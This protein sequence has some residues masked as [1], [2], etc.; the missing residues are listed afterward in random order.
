MAENNQDKNRTDSFVS[1]TKGVKVGHYTIIEK[2]GAG[3][4]GEVYLAEDTELKRQVALKFLPYHFVSDETAK[5]RFTRE[6]QAAAKLNHPN[7]VTIY[8]VSN[9][10]GRPFFAM[11]CCDGKPLRDIIKKIELS[12]DD[13]IKLTIQICEGLEKAHQAGIVHRDIKPSNIVIGSDERPKLLDFGLATVKGTEKLTQTGS[14]LG[15]IGYMSPEQI[16]VKEIDH[17]SDLFSL[18][19]VFYEMITG[20]LPFKGDTE[21]GTLNSILNDTPEPLSRYK[22]NV[23]DELQQI[24]TKLLEKNLEFRYQSAA[25][26]LS[27]LK[28]LSSKSVQTAKPIDKWNRYVVPS[29]LVLL[30]A[31]FVIWKFVYKDQV[32]NYADTK[33]IMLAV[34]PLENLGD[35]EDEYFADGIT[36]EITTN[37]AKLSGLGVISRTSSMQYKNSN[38]NLKQIGKELKVDFILEGTIRWDK[39]SPEN[40]VRINPQLIRVSDDMHLWAESYEAV[41]NDVFGVQSSIAREVV[42]ALDITLLQKEN[43]VITQKNKIDPVA[44]D[45]Y[46][47]GKQYYTVDR[48]QRTQI[49]LAIKMHEKAIETAPDF[50]LGYAE[51]GAI[52]TEIYWANINPSP[53]RLDT[54]KYYIDKAMALAPNSSEAHQALGWYYYHGLRDFDRAVETFKHVLKLHPNNSQAMASI[55]WVYRRQGKWDEA[56]ELL[57]QVIRL[58]PRKST[59]RFELGFTLANKRNYEE[60]FENFNLAIDLQ[61]DIYWA[62]LMKSFALLNQTG[63][64][65]QSKQV[66][67]QAL[68]SCG[69]YPA[70]TFFETYYNLIDRNYEK[71]LSLINAPGEIYLW[72]DIGGFDYYYFKGATYKY[73]KNEN[74][75]QIYF[76]SARVILEKLVSKTPNSAPYFSSLAKIYAFLGRKDDAISTAKRAIEIEPISVDAINGTDYI[77]DIII[78]Y[79]EVGEF[80][81]AIDQLDYLLKIPSMYSIN[82]VKLAPEL[83]PLHDHPRFQAL[84]EKYEKKE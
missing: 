4:M 81:L 75:A 84:I 23:P 27:D 20:R 58:D 78:V 49:D 52:H 14:T 77:R 2:I 16:Q 25:G 62:Y 47:R 79:A 60:A 19:V 44:Y 54:A 35:P 53:G 37:L 41:L 64:V 57:K 82:W 36:E 48:P 73:M 55:A 17:R 66:I 46:L 24:V 26:V 50:A 13:T 22:S 8:E 39:S 28:R 11:E 42:M 51:L 67:E 74:M 80:D 38:K 61:P 33:K 30:I 59:Y 43:D 31:I 40:R 15:T 1:L 3:G 32:P 56:I 65:S 72:Q 69:R 34:L 9:Y 5:A 7:I 21:A 18:G 45:Y 71:A 6:A 12:I 63:D 83:V 76:D 29:A 68:T 10:M 70:L